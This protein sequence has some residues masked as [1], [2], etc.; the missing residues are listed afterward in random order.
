MDRDDD[1]SHKSKDFPFASLYLLPHPPFV[2]GNSFLHAP[3]LGEKTGT[4]GKKRQIIGF[5]ASKQILST[6][7]LSLLT[8]EREMKIHLAEAGFRGRFN[9][10]G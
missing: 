2:N 7:H 4:E 6:L 3:L 1:F 8:Q 9:A 5:L 10:D